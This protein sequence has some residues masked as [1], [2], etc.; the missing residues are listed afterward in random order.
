[1]ACFPVIIFVALKSALSQVNIFTLGG[2]SD[3]ILEASLL[4][5][6]LE[7]FTVGLVHIESPTMYQL[8]FIFSYSGTASRGNLCTPASPIL[9]KCIALGPPLFSSFPSPRKAVDFSACS[10]FYFLLSCSG[11]F[12]SLYLQN[13]KLEVCLLNFL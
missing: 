2:E 7:F 4:L 1:M 9:G 13:Q 8:Q 5:G 6:C 10:A 12:Q 3:S 11:D